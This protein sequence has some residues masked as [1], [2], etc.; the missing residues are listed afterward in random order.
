MRPGA[1]SYLRRLLVPGARKTP[2]GG[3]L[4]WRGCRFQRQAQRRDDLILTQ[5]V[6]VPL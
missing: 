5:A 4:T 3:R 2:P 6:R 1:T